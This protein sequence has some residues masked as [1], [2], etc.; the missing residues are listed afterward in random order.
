MRITVSPSRI[1]VS[2]GTPQPVAVTISNPGSV[3]AGYTVRILGADP[4]WV[5]LDDARISLFPD[6]SRTITAILTVPPGLAAGERR[7]AVQVRE[8]TPPERTAIEEVVL[9]VPEAGSAVVRVDPVTV[10]TG[11]TGRFS[12]LVENSGNTRIDGWLAADDSE[13][14]LRYRFEPERVDLA[15]GEHAVLD[16]RARGRRPWIGQPVVRVVNVHLTRGGAGTTPAPGPTGR[17]G[18]R[19]STPPPPDPEAPPVATASM[20]QKALLSRGPIGL[21][22]L[23]AAIT[24][25]AVVITV[26]LSRIVGQSAADRNLALEIAAAND[27]AAAGSGSSG[28]TGTV[29]QL[30]SG[31]PVEGVAVI[32]YA[33]GQLVTPLATLATDDA[34]LWKISGLPAGD[35]QLAIRGA[36]FEPI[37]YPT[38]LDAENAETVTVEDDNI[39]AGLDVAIGGTPA[40][41]SG[42]LVGDD[43]SDATVTLKTPATAVVA[44]Q[45]GTDSAAAPTATTTS[46]DDEVLVPARGIVATTRTR[47]PPAPAEPSPLAPS[48]EGG[49]TVQTV[50]VGSDGAFSFGNVPSPSVYDLVVTKKGYA[51]ATQR[52]DVSAG[53]NREG[54]EIHLL[55]GDGIISGE[56]SSDGKPLGGVTL[57]A[58][59]G[60]TSASTV[61]LTEGDKGSFTLRRLPTPGT[62]TVVAT[63]DGFA[64]QTVSLSLAEGQALTG[65]S[66]NLGAAAGGLEGKASILE[67]G[68]AG[69]VTVTVTDG[70][71]TIQTAT[72]SVPKDGRPIGSWR[73]SGLQ[74]PG[75]YTV[76]LSRD[77]LA[78]QTVS[79]TLDATGA[80]APS[81]I[82]ATVTSNGIETVMRSSSAVVRGVVRQPD[83][84]GVLRRVGEVTVQLSSGTT[85]FTVVAAS[86]PADRRGWYRIENVPPGTYTV[87]VSRP[88]V[89]PTSDIIHLTAGE[90]EEY[91]PQLLKAASLK[92]VVKD[93]DTGGADT[94]ELLVELYRASDYPA[95]VYR[96][97]RADANGNYFFDDIDAPEVYVVQVRRN[98]GS[99]P[100]GS[101]NVSVDAS[102]QAEK[103]V[104]IDD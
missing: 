29:R 93:R 19:G 20:V 99:V 97:T 21:V 104:K 70:T 30:T 51:T 34:G 48:E 56:V 49:A 7:M 46:Y 31:D 43:V 57:T 79:V 55:Q 5:T 75:T 16:L 95:V 38:S 32:V 100:V 22:G 35:Y 66:L 67:G 87:S 9:V 6:E 81:S 64:T 103:D 102:E 101:A 40:T 23:L 10:T 84:G 8:L 27:A 4:S 82:G 94:R 44:P 3:I 90:D 80:V 28:M 45:E 77:D 1:E 59:S 98:R 26:A 92:G 54:V 74:I 72:Q 63:K 88:G 2:P 65:V 71:Q 50:A 68:P 83:S 13:G 60:Q 96:T 52:I 18:K 39:V 91:H 47:A 76:T 53:E 85:S 11:R 17:Q 41:I 25:F 78:S 14:K 15:P 42:T 62:Y 36:G 33:A 58:T 89:R 73:V 12:L 61:S 37:W 24:V 86:V 69:G